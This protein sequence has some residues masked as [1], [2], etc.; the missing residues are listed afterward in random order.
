MEALDRLK[1]HFADEVGDGDVGIKSATM[2][3]AEVDRAQRLVK[4]MVTTTRP[5]MDNEVVLPNFD[6][7][8]FP[9]VSGGAVSAV[10][11]EH[12]YEI[13]GKVAAVGACRGFSVRQDG[14]FASTHV[15]ESGLGDDILTAI[16]AGAL[17][18]LS[19]GFR[20]L[21]ASPPDDME[22]KAFG[23]AVQ[24]VVRHSKLLEYSFT[25]IPCNPGALIEQDSLAKLD[26]LVTKNAIRRKS[27]V[28]MGLPTTPERKHWPTREIV[29]RGRVGYVRG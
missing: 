2:R 4:G 8:Y 24:T 11:L 12:Q 26:E 9:K 19:I 13:E 7:S 17:G 3:K 18:G 28:L 29:L 5:D 20:V 16:E 27:A 25:C 10:F 1:T 14:A 23:D 21:D 22:V 15:L 6:T